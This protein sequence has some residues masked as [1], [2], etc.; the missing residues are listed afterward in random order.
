MTGQPAMESATG[1]MVAM[2]KEIDNMPGRRLVD[3][4]E[5]AG[6]DETDHVK[7]GHS[8][9]DSFIPGLRK[10]LPEMPS[11]HFAM[12]E[13]AVEETDWVYLAKEIIAHGHKQKNA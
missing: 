12:I 11:P 2:F 5:Q 9:R 4:I 1:I 7:I 8:L 13:A 10:V 3:V 6:V